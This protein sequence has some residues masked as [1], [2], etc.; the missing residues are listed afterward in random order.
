MRPDAHFPAAS[1]IVVIGYVYHA[2]GQEIRVKLEL[3]TAEVFDG[4]IS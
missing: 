4:C 2:A 1:A 3:F